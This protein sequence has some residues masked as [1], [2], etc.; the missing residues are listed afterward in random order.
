MRESGCDYVAGRVCDPE[1]SSVPG[2]PGV[3]CS[4]ELGGTRDAF[5]E[6]ATYEQGKRAQR[7]VQRAWCVQSLLS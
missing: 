3:S 7:A 5:L 6:E 1:V 2:T 4:L